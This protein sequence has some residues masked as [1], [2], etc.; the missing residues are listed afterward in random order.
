MKDSDIKQMLVSGS[1]TEAAFAG[2]NYSIEDGVVTLMG[3]VPSDKE[4]GKVEERVKHTSGV[5]EVVN[6]LTVSPV[7]LDGDFPL[8]QS[9]DSVLTRYPMVV[10]NVEDSVVVVSGTAKED[11]LQQLAEGL[12]G[13]NPKGLEMQ[14]GTE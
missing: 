8:K 3:S 14:V 5:K 9:V 4:R 10:A 11:D 7:V 6:H 2:V 12:T 1:K 13:L